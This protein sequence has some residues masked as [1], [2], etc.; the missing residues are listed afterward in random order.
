MGKYLLLLQAVIVTSFMINSS[1][2]A[3]R[4][5]IINGEETD[6]QNFPYQIVYLTNGTFKCGGSIISK[7]CVVTAGEW[8]GNTRRSSDQKLIIV[9]M[10]LQLAHCVAAFPKNLTVRAGSSFR[11]SG[12]VV[13]AVEEAI[14]HPKYN[15]RTLFHDIAVLKLSE[16]LTFSDLIQPI[17]LNCEDVPDNTECIVSG[18][19]KTERGKS[20]EVLRWVTL[21]TINRASCQIDYNDSRVRYTL[22]NSTM[23]AGLTQAPAEG[24]MQ[25][26]S[27]SGDSVSHQMLLIS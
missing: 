20:S 24:Q 26:D 5:G 23:C 17:A 22:P 16:N 27:C 2:S 19:G 4:F 9:F 13:I 3:R 21:Q 8:V 25:K 10:S 6:I 14:I 1:L 12:G 15:R 7:N 11:S 18:W